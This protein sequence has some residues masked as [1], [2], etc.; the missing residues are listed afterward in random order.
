MQLNH[1]DSAGNAIMVDVSDK[2]E[3]VRTATAHGR[4][5]MNPETFALISKDKID[6]GDVL[7]VA[8]V[9][10][11]MA[12]KRTSE[13]IPMCHNILIESCSVDFVMDKQHSEIEARCTVV[14]SGKT[15]IEMEA[16]V[17]VSL[18]LAT[19]YDMC[20]AGDRAMTIHSIRLYEK[21]GGRSGHYKYEG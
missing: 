3:T 12:T 17:G 18:A 15:G 16:I 13:L 2:P 6:K 5:S 21:S 19:I 1:F 20:K 10:G 7:G 4:I 14:T 8:R 11:I 9:A